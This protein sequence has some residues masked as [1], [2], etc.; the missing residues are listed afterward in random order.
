MFPP[1]GLYSSAP[2]HM[3]VKLS[4]KTVI[5]KSVGAHLLVYIFSTNVAKVTVHGHATFVSFDESVAGM[6]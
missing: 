3:N 5:M 4:S 6:S 2:V 1:R